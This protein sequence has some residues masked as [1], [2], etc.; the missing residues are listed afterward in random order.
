MAAIFI[1]LESGE[2]RSLIVGGI[3]FQARSVFDGL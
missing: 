2:E 1:D 3:E